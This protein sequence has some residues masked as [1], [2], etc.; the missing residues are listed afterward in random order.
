MGRK[1][2]PR[3]QP[4]RRL[5]ISPRCSRTYTPHKSTNDHYQRTRSRRLPFQVLHRFL[6]FTESIFYFISEF[7]YIFFKEQARRTA[8]VAASKRRNTMLSHHSNWDA[9]GAPFMAG[10]DSDEEFHDYGGGPDDYD[11]DDDNANTQGGDQLALGEVPFGGQEYHYDED[12]RP[13]HQ[14]SDLDA[15]PALQQQPQHQHS[16]QP[17]DEIVVSNGS[18]EDLC[19]QKIVRPECEFLCV[20][21]CVFLT[22]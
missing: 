20:C 5:S 10:D 8:I 18:Y 2:Q 7:D 1:R 12:P 21:V 13:H 6:S 3:P 16:L 4:Q 17:V 19:H 9:S 15:F 14:Q 11:V 22:S